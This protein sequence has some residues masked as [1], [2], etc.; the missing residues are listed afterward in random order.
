MDDKRIQFLGQS[1]GF[2]H[3][4]FLCQWHCYFSN[5]L[6]VYYLPLYLFLEKER[7][8]LSNILKW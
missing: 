3:E 6:N 2:E 7:F 4:L 8:M 5:V 1:N